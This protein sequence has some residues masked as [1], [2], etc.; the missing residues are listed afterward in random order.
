MHRLRPISR[1][2]LVASLAALGACSG[3]EPPARPTVVLITLDTTRAENLSTYGYRRPTDPFL[4]SLAQR[5]R[6]FERAYSTGTWTLPSHVSMFSGLHPAEHGC[7][8]RLDKRDGETLFPVVGDDLPLVT[9]SLL[10]AGYSLIGAVGGPFT[11]SQYGL[12]R[13]FDEYIQPSGVDGE[14][15]LAGSAINARLF[16]LLAEVDAARPLFLFVNYFDAHAPYDPPQDRVYPFPAVG[17]LEFMEGQRELHPMPD[18]TEWQAQG[19]EILEQHE[20]LA[21]ANYDQELLLQDEALEALMGE[22]ERLGRLDDA[23]VIVTADHGEMFGEQRGAYGHSCRPW[24]P[25]T[26]VPLVVYR[27][28]GPVDR[29]REPASV[30]QIAAT[31]LDELGLTQLPPGAAGP[32]PSLLASSPT[33]PEALVEFR[34]P[35]EWVGAVHAGNLKLVVDWHARD[36]ALGERD[37]L[38]IDLDSNPS[39]DPDRVP[40]TTAWNATRE[41][42]L[43]R[44]EALHAKW[45]AWPEM[46]RLE[47]L[48]GNQIAGLAALGYLTERAPETVEGAPPVPEATT[49]DY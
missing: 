40:R 24:E 36:S 29:R 41:P 39:E 43:E 11:S 48:D 32:V 30:A 18:M 27:S 46:A 4:R 5:S 19:W 31:I 45:L 1:C 3:P 6:V 34:T 20:R 42:L 12:A 37:A 47:V 8:F 13:D 25:V 28:G 49:G 44:A 15:Q 9:G 38:L 16:P 21:I 35:D 7:W 10:D 14:W 2:V 23:L 26:R 17:E 22:L 33:P